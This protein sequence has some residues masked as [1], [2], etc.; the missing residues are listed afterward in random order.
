MLW[1]GLQQPLFVGLRPRAKAFIID[2]VASAE[3][4][5]ELPPT[6]TGLRSPVVS[7]P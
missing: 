4:L 3:D 5:A 1:L 6:R 7:S 2:K